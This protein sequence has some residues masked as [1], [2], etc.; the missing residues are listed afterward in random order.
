MKYMM[1]TSFGYTILISLIGSLTLAIYYSVKI[2]SNMSS[3]D[4][5]Y[6]KTECNALEWY[7]RLKGK[8]DSW[9]GCVYQGICVYGWNDINRTKVI[10]EDTDYGKLEREL[11]ISC[12][13][14]IL[15]VCYASDKN[16]KF[17]AYK[18][19]DDQIV[20]LVFG[21]VLTAIFTL[22]TFSCY[23]YVRTEDWYPI[24]I[25]S[26]PPPYYQEPYNKV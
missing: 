25:P 21:V 16:I 1:I 3:F 4:S 8:C 13:E 19:K 22:I 5:D 26:A 12:S 11:N 20:A 23:D 24:N 18:P 10:S 9:K 14:E 7:I 6:V 15:R 17:S 2:G